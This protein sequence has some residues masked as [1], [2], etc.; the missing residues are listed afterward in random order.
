MARVFSWPD[1]KEAGHPNQKFAEPTPPGTLNFP[2]LTDLRMS[3]VT[4]NIFSY[5]LTGAKTSRGE[6]D[7][8]GEELVASAA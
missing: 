8:Q 4:S 6:D 1:R 5:T 3:Q 7:R 2:S